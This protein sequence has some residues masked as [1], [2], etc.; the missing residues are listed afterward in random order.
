MANP[1][2]FGDGDRT[3]RLCDQC[4]GKTLFEHLF[5]EQAFDVSFALQALCSTAAASFLSGDPRVV[6][7]SPVALSSARRPS[8]RSI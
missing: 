3:D 1:P 6:M 4:L 8:P 5:V 7:T 2:T